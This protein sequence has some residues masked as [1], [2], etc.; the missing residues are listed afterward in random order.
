MYLNRT[1]VRIPT[2][3]IYTVY[4]PTP[5]FRDIIWFSFTYT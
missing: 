5:K 4:F 2:N 3:Y 1:G